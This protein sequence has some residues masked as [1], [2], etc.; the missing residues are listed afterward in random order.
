MNR[1]KTGIITAACALLLFPLQ[2]AGAIYTPLHKHSSNL[3]TTTPG[4]SELLKNA[5]NNG[6]IVDLDGASPLCF[7]KLVPGN[8]YITLYHRNHLPIMTPYAVTVSAYP[9]LQ[10]DFTLSQSQAYS[11]N[12][13][14]MKQISSSPSLYAMY[15]GDGDGNGVIQA[16]DNYLCTNDYGLSGYRMTDHNMNTIVNY[17]D[18]ILMFGNY[19]KYTQVP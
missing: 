19:G 3:T 6:H 11:W 2:H 13:N 4:R 10:Y 8:Y 5:K 14:P 9:M 12:A 16:N 7:P 1:A 17:A 18:H 15:A